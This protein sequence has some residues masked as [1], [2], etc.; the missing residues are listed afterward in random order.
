MQGECIVG[1]LDREIIIARLHSPLAAQYLSD[2]RALNGCPLP[3]EQQLEGPHTIPSAFAP[4]F[5]RMLLNGRDVRLLSHRAA[6]RELKFDGYKLP[7]L[8]AEIAR[9]LRLWRNR[10]Q[11][12]ERRHAQENE[13]YFCRPAIRI[14]GEPILELVKLRLSTG[15]R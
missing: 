6:M 8:R 9:E 15:F 2:L 7:T 4:V 11:R 5:D 1:S 10:W 13:A 3:Y 14:I 12:F